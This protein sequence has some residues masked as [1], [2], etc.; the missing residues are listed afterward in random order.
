[1]SFHYQKSNKIFKYLRRKNKSSLITVINGIPFYQSTGKNSHQPSTWFPFRGMKEKTKWI[2]KPRQVESE[3]YPNELNNFIKESDLT[4]MVTIKRFGNLQTMCISAQINLGFWQTKQGV[5]LKNFL[6]SQ[7]PDLFI[8]NDII[9]EI[10]QDKG[11]YEEISSPDKV[12]QVLNE[13]GTI[14]PVNYKY[15]RLPSY[16][17]SQLLNQLPDIYPVHLAMRQIYSLKDKLDE[18]IFVTIVKSIQMLHESNL[19]ERA[20]LDLI[21]KSKDKIIQLNNLYQFKKLRG[22]MFTKEDIEYINSSSQRSNNEQILVEQTD[23]LKDRSLIV[24]IKVNRGVKRKYQ[25]SFL[26]DP[27][28]EEKVDPQQEDV[29]SSKKQKR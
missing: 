3:Y 28:T 18:S 1:M 27:I 2:M 11:N 24:N 25:D 26:N 4:T 21:F 9:N 22:E 14:I 13:L 15:S 12:N 17:E 29:Q 7:Y 10:Q 23:N 20:A 5:Q 8:K 6:I 19:L 16:Q